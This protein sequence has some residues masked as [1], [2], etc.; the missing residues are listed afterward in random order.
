[1]ASG[2]G[3]GATTGEEAAVDKKAPEMADGAAPAHS[4]ATG[5]GKEEKVLDGERLSKGDQGSAK[6]T[7]SKGGKSPAR[8]SRRQCTVPC[9]VSLLDGSVFPCD[10]DKQ[11]KGQVLF[12]LVCEHLNLLEKDYFGLNYRDNTEQKEEPCLVIFQNWLDPNKEIKRQVRA[13]AWTFIFNTKFYPPDPAQLTEDITRYYICLQLREDVASGRLPCSFVTHA[14]LGSYA[15][16]AELGDHEPDEHGPGYA[17]E[18]RFAPNQTPELEDKVVELH[19]TH[20]N[21]TPA[22]ADLHFLENA[23]KLSMY[24]VDLHHAR[25][26]EGLDIMLGVCANGLLIYRDRLR[27]N[28][29]AWP[30]IL[31]I[32]YKRTNFYIKIRPGEFEQFEST[33]GFKLPTHRAAKRLWKTCIEHHAFFR[34]VSADPQPK[35]RIFTLGSRFRYSG[36]TQAETRQMSAAI[37]RPAPAFQRSSSKRKTSTRS[38]D[39]APMVSDHE[40]VSLDGAAARDLQPPSVGSNGAAKVEA[41]PKAS[42]EP[43]EAPRSAVDKQRRQGDDGA[44][45]AKVP[46]GSSK[47]GGSVAMAT[48]EDGTTPNDQT[49]TEGEGERA[50]SSQTP[51]TGRENHPSRRVAGENVF[52]RHSRLMLEGLDEK[53]EHAVRHQAN[54]AELKRSFLGAPQTADADWNKRFSGEG[55]VPATADPAAKQSN[56]DTAPPGGPLANGT[57]AK[58]EQ[59]PVVQTETMSFNSAA[60]ASGTEITTRDVPIVATETKTITYEAPQDIVENDGQPGLLMSA[61]TITSETSSST[62][63]TH[64]TKTVKDGISETRIEKRIVISGDSDL[65]HDQALA[66]AIKEAK[67]QHPDMAVTRVVVHKETEVLAT[68]DHE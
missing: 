65:D 2:V 26:S 12:D 23:K 64:I 40:K 29:F 14:V 19:K 24:G 10:V 38:L 56:G 62:M 3:A 8:G 7:P 60:P 25:D 27:I 44:R 41:L 51:P 39:R 34:L 17:S 9:S 30:K 37:D 48:P 52:V 1:M 42:A 32:S 31:K 68:A 59:P 36:R 57:E 46:S 4:N 47:G 53:P 33:I 66:Q 16:Q 28:R 61:Q 55:G 58:P 15:L 63:T 50:G 20:R 13:G 18:F 45:A 54:L 6:S 35:S 67:E 11:A 5:N 43:H 22:E 21:M 49:S